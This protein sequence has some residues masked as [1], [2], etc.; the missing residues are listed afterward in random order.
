[1]LAHVRD[2]A[3]ATYTRIV[4]DVRPSDAALD[5]VEDYKPRKCPQ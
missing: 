4:R 5:L 1:M 2:S 3:P